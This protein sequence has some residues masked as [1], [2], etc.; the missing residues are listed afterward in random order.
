MPRSGGGGGGISK[1]NAVFAAILV[2]VFGDDLH[3]LAREYE[4]LRAVAQLLRAARVHHA[5]LRLTLQ[6][7]L[8]LVDTCGGAA[9]SADQAHGVAMHDAVCVRLA[10]LGMPREEGSARAD[11][12]AVV[13]MASAC[14]ELRHA[15]FALASTLSYPA[16]G[17]PSAEAAPEADAGDAVGAAPSGTGVA[18]ASPHGAGGWPWA[19]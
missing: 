1:R 13:R 16:L 14:P 5:I 7:A 10:E 11:P 3:V 15:G 18:A 4:Q 9:P 19:G 17:K 6:A 2:D 8:D 12:A